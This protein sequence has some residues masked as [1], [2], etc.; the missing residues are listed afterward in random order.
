MKV[1]IALPMYDIND[2][3]K[4]LAKITVKREP[5]SRARADFLIL[6]NVPTAQKLGGQ[7]YLTEKELKW[8]GEKVRLQLKKRPKKY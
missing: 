1:L 4:E 3:C 6:N 2:V 5:Y 8:L 7:Y